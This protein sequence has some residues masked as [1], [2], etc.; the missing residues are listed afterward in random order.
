MSK[1]R[2]SGIGATFDNEATIMEMRFLAKI[3]THRKE[4]KYRNSF[5]RP[6]ITYYMRNMIMVVGHSFVL[7]EKE[8]V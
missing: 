6:L 3:Y 5:L 8:K 7:F 2:T 4:E 1:I